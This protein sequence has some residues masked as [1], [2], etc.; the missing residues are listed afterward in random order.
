MKDLP[1]VRRG[2]K[3]RHYTSG[4][5]VVGEKG[6]FYSP[7]DYGGVPIH[8]GVI[9]DGE[10]V[11]INKITRPRDAD[12]GDSPFSKFKDIEFTRSPG[13][14]EELG[15]AITDGGQPMSNFPGYSGPLSES[16]LL[17]NLSLWAG[18]KVEWDAKAMIAKDVDEST[19]KLI[20]HDYPDEFTVHET[21]KVG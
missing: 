8:T 9:M 3:E 4:A 6:L 16:I 11:R 21:T 15:K 5:V 13:H 10:F 1:K 2:D 17:G 18:K 19:Q 14:V 12:G 7:G 20:R